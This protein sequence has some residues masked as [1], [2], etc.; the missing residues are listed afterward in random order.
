[1]GRPYIV[2]ADSFNENN[3]GVIALHRLCDLLNR[4]GERAW[5]WPSRRPLY[6]PDRKLASGWG[7]FRWYRRAW[8]RPYRMCPGFQTTIA[9]PAELEGA[10]AIYPEIVHGNPLRTEH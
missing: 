6:D 4:G 3:G 1:M 5:L 2:F 10:I 8:R 9:T 7:F